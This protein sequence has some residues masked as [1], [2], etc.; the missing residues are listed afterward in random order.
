M[1]RK[2]APPP[3]PPP[4]V[5]KEQAK[6][7]AY[8][9]EKL[10]WSIDQMIANTLH[11]SA[12]ISALDV[13]QAMTLLIAL[14]QRKKLTPDEFLALL[15]DAVNGISLIE[16]A[17][18]E[19]RVLRKFGPVMTEEQKDALMADVKETSK[20]VEF[21]RKSLYDRFM[22]IRQCAQKGVTVH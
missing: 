1:S 20:A 6:E 5:D 14:G 4:E 9:D 16:A 13:Q 15:D 21:R 17:K 22:L 11:P 12:P 8:V 7:D 2:K 3:A 10:E 19:M 18:S